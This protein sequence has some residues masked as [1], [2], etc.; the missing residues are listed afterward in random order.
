MDDQLSI[1]DIR[2]LF[3]LFNYRVVEQNIGIFGDDGQVFKDPTKE[4]YQVVDEYGNEVTVRYSDYCEKS[5]IFQW[6]LDDLREILFIADEFFVMTETDSFDPWDNATASYTNDVVISC[7][8][9]IFKGKSPYEM[10][11]AYDLAK[12]S[13]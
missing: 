1:E 7:H 11:I 2:K 3:S 8:K 6:S 9:N 5:G 10:L 12:N 4:P 13:V